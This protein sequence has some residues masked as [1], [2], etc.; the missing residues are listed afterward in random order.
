MP[1]KVADPT[2]SLV[3]DA[4]VAIATVAETHMKLVC[5]DVGYDPELVA[6]ELATDLAAESKVEVVEHFGLVVFGYGYIAEPVGI[7]FAVVRL[8]RKAVG[9][10]SID[11]AALGFV[12]ET[13]FAE[14]VR[15]VAGAGFLDTLVELQLAV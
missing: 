10:A 2:M 11:S 5:F 1:A 12:V 3:L 15:K 6:G 14:T 7:D 8:V 9:A 4:Q 13:D